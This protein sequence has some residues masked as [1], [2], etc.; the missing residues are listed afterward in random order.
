[1]KPNNKSFYKIIFS[2]PYVLNTYLHMVVKDASRCEMKEIYNLL[3]SILE[4]YEL[5]SVQEECI[6]DAL[7]GLTGNCSV[8]CYIGTGDYHL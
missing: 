6:L 5:N 7:D 2:H 1:M 8:L 4:H 3:C